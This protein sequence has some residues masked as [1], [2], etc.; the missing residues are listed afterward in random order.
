MY[1]AIIVGGG[2]A[3]LN[4]AL[5]LGRCRR[6]VLLC[7]D[8]TPRNA[9]S[10]G[11]SGFITRDGILPGELRSIGRAEIGKYPSVEIRDMP[12]ADVEI[13]P[14][15]FEVVMN[16]GIRELARKLLLATGVDDN[17]PD[18][19]G[20]RELYGHGVY[21]CP[22]CDGWEERDRLFA[23][24]G[25]GDKGKNFALQ[26]TLWGKD[27]VLCTDGASELSETDLAQLERNG[28]TVREDRI[29]HL[30]AKN[31]TLAAVHF[32]NDSCLPR[33]AL[34]FITGAKP[35]CAIAT[36]LNCHLTEK[37]VVRTVGN[38]Q[39][40][41]PGLFVAGDASQ[42]VQFA[43]LAAAEGAL[44]AF[45]INSELIAEDLI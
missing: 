44:A 43:I 28:V 17:L 21:N 5:V 10:R 26:L 6:R 20:F 45:Q 37:G 9:V 34:F 3:G 2:P 7:D 36:K 11:V 16:D 18:I 31:D 29:T 14:D 8:G 4:A 33:D 30:E 40:N 27:P 32:E 39:T 25:R 24:Y 1:D 15:G 12:V 19:P 23:I 38:E 42:G 13:T 35:S 22:Y 41:I